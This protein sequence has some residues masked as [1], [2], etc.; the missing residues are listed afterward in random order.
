[1]WSQGTRDP[2]Q[3][4]YCG[5]IDAGSSRLAMFTSICVGV[6]VP[7]KAIWVPQLAQN[8]RRPRDEDRYDRG[9][10][11]AKKKLVVGKLAQARTGA[12]LER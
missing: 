4:W 8:S 6:A 3:I 11:F 1:M 5:S 12:P 7:R 10:P 2:V 9:S